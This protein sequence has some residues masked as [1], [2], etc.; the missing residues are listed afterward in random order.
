MRI[1]PPRSRMS[2]PV[3]PVAYRSPKMA[4]AV[5]SAAVALEGVA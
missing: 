5:I 2:V 3:L 1:V 4:A